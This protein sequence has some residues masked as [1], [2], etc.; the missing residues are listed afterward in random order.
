ME[1]EIYCDESRQELF[2]T[3]KESTDRYMVIGSI[4]I[5]KDNRSSLKNK[6]KQVRAKYNISRGEIKWQYVAPSKLDF[7]KEVVK[8]F[9]EEGDSVR[10]RC[11]VVDTKQVDL[12]TYHDSDA[13]LGFY[14][15]YYELLHQWIRGNDKY[16]IYTDIKTTRKKNRLKELHRILNRASLFADI[17]S[18][19]AIPSKESVFIQLADLLIGA[20]GYSCHSYSKSSAKN[21]IVKLI[22]D[23]IKRSPCEGTVRDEKKFNVF[24]IQLDEDVW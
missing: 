17:V 9:F 14:K 4:W 2:T 24:K 7:Y 18:V 6:I 12:A 23:E 1:I 10:F 15:F 19:Q 3:S 21:E 5:P 22:A 20:V 16:F 11:I 8:K 13:E